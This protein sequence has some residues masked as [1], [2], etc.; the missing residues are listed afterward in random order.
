MFKKLNS[1]TLI[2]VFG[3]L[4][5]LVV[6][7]KVVQH[8]KGDRNFNAKFFE[9]DTAKVS[10]IIIKPRGSKDEVHLVRNGR[11]W[12]LE[13][14]GKTYRVEKNSVQ[15]LLYELVNLKPDHL[16]AMDK[17]DWSQYQVTDTAA[18]RVKVEQAGKVVADFFLGKF[19]FQQYQQTSYVRVNNDD[20]VYAVNGIPAMTFN[21]SADDFR[22][23]LL[24]QINHVPDITKLDFAYPDSSFVMQKD[25]NSWVV[26]GEKLDSA[27]V[28]TYL[29]SISSLYALEFV[30]DAVT[31]GPLKFSLRIEGKNFQPVEL[32]AY[33]ADAANRYAITSN[34]NPDGKFSGLKGDLAKRIFV[35]KDNFKAA[36]K[37]KK[38]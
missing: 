11:E 34:M 21:K 19:S 12:N 4:L 5:L 14:K 31:P 36:S 35:G 6:L 10:A 2:I 3:V 37:I 13:K 32:K 27:K 9:V 38:K 33:E 29:N 18:T 23:K 25:N 1:K 28:A 17:T 15:P 24:V 7:L 26:N 20:N 30:D 16:A 22:N 8:S